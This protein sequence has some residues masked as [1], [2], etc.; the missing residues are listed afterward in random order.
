MEDFILKAYEYCTVIIPFVIM[1]IILN[2]AYQK[3]ESKMHTKG[4]FLLFIYTVYISA[5]FYFTGSGTVYQLLMYG[6]ESHSN[7]INLLP[8]SNP[9]DYMGYFLNVLLFI[10]FG[11][12]VP[13]IWSGMKKLRYI[14]ASGFCFSLLIE[15]SQML[16][17]RSTDIDDLLLNTIG[18]VIGYIFCCIYLKIT[19]WGSNRPYQHF[20]FEP[21]LYIGVM[22]IGHFLLFYEFGIAKILYHF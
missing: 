9:I 8:F 2:R 7:S 15:L 11:F 4:F 16:N 22:F 14:I 6:I 12:F 21:L 5:V 1:Y 17:H 13:L 10:P 20:K 3:R 18:T 19:G